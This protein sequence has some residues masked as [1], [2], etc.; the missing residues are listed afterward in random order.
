MKK[1]ILMALLSA[2][3][4][5][6]VS[7][8]KFYDSKSMIIG[9]SGNLTELEEGGFSNKYFRNDIQLPAEALSTGKKY[10]KQKLL[11]AFE[12][13]R[14]GK[15]I[16]DMLFQ[17]DGHSLS[18]SLLKDRAFQN[19]QL[20]D[21]E[22]AQIGVIDKETIL[23]ED[24]LP[25]LESNYIFLTR[26]VNIGKSIGQLLVEDPE[27]DDRYRTYWIVFKVDITKDILE[28]V[29]NCWNDMN[30]YD[31]INVPIKYV[32][33]GCFKKTT[34]KTEEV[35]NLLAR[36]VSQKVEAFA[37]RGQITDNH[38]LTV[39]IGGFNGVQQGDRMKI[40]R[41]KVNSKNE[42]SSVTIANTRAGYVSVNSTRLFALSGQS[43]SYKKGDIAVIRLD[44]G[45]GHSLTYNLLSM[46]YE[47]KYHGV[48]YTF[49]K[50]FAFNKHGISSYAL[51][52]IGLIMDK[53]ED[54]D[55]EF[56]HGIEYDDTP[57]ILNV[58]FGLGFGKT[59]FSRVE[60]MPYAMV[61]Y[62]YALG[63]E[64]DY[65]DF[66]EA[67]RIPIGVKANVNILYPLQLTLG[68]EYNFMIQ[69]EP[70]ESWGDSEGAIYKGWGISAGL[71]VVF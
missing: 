19:V 10:N 8:R 32:A 39:N 6:N 46:E 40:Y 45:I 24:Y 18:E 66:T 17:Y 67:V 7:A 11:K 33:S 2:L 15:K 56:D 48:S 5:F 44:R 21:E 52:S 59:F 26:T 51:G 3:N 63:E 14:T 64:D 58:G 55:I 41:Q 29:F 28:Q 16:L 31:Q 53:S 36:S 20:M 34:A 1:I 71:R 60:I 38:P 69:K 50:R 4:I 54:I 68:A 35:R 25:I 13:E 70:E 30:K 61:H 22:R 23:R 27:K 47:T 49:D 62:L 9:I 42:F 43:S 65:E 37:I 12:R 57:S